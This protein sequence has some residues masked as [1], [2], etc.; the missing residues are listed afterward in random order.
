MFSL[1][2]LLF[3]CVYFIPIF[4]YLLFL[5]IKV[6]L[7]R[8]IIKICH[9]NIL[10]SMIHI[11]TNISIFLY[12]VHMIIYID[13]LDNPFY[14]NYDDSFSQMSFYSTSQYNCDSMN[15][16]ITS[17]FH[18]HSQSNS[19]SENPKFL[20]TYQNLIKSLPTYH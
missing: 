12:Y 17:V 3:E 16:S 20:E 7:L 6:D 15:Q 14:Q 10:L 1:L 9:L 19:N 8:Q 4:K 5:L 11:F 2:K 18:S 13:S